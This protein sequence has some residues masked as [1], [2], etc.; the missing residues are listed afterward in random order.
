MTG[1]NPTIVTPSPVMST[2]AAAMSDDL[3]QKYAYS[4]SL[5]VTL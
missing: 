4:V 1:S 5:V 3:E 2:P